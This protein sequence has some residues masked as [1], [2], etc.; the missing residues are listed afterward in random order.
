MAQTTGA[1]NLV[2]AQVEISANG[3]TWYDISG[4]TNK[5]ICAP[6]EA[7]V[8]E[9]ATLDGQFM[10]GTAGKLKPVKL[11]VTILYTETANEAFRIIEAQAELAARPLWVRWIPSR[12]TGNFVYTTANPAGVAAAGI[13][14]KFPRPGADAATAGPSM[15]DFSVWVSRILRSTNNPSP[16]L[17]PSASASPSPSS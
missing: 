2:D 9:A 16:S 4:S 15:L 5:L 1:M 6:Q 8:G 17:S 14:T 12:G 7:D 3:T 13:L 10:I 11:D